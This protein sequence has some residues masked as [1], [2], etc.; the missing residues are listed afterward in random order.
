MADVNDDAA[1]DRY[2]SAAPEDKEAAWLEMWRERDFTWTGRTKNAALQSEMVQVP[3]FFPND[4]DRDGDFKNVSLKDYWR[5]SIGLPG[6][7]YREGGYK[8]GW[9]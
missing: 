6:D 3:A 4:M 5:W 7:E 2:D 1:T 8:R 9:E